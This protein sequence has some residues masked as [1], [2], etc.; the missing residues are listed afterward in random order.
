MK[1]ALSVN[2]TQNG[3]SYKYFE[4]TYQ[5]VAD[6]EKSPLLESGVMP[7]PSIKGAKQEDH[8][9]YIFTGY[10]Y[11]P[12]DG[13]YEFSTRSDDGSVL[14]IG[15][16]KVVDNDASH[17]AIDAMGRIPLQKGYHPFALHYFEDYEGEYLGWSWRTP[18]MSKL[19]AIPTENLYIN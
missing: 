3:T 17:A 1:A 7:E 10:I 2:P 18:S 4:G 14:Y 5:K 13:V 8:F 9:G 12:E 19:D 11:A 15:K 6:V 16:E